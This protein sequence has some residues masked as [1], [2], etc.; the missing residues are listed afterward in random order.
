[1]SQFLSDFN[2]RS[3]TGLRSRT[4]RDYTRKFNLFMSVCV[5][6]DLKRLD[7]IEA[8]SVFLE[9]LIKRGLKAQTLQSYMSGVFEPSG[10]NTPE[11]YVCAQTLL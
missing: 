1:M 2:A 8:V 5:Y 6:F 11:L 10:S 3:G 7:S 9:Y 4:A